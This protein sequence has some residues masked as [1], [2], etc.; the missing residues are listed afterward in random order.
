[1]D[2]SGQP[3]SRTTNFIKMHCVFLLMVHPCTYLM[4]LACAFSP[5]SRAG[6]HVFSDE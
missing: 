5:L 6:V 1:M 2:M 3:I 4:L